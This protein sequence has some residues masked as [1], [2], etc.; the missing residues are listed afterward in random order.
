M[1]GDYGGF[2]TSMPYDI[3]LMANT[4]VYNVVKAFGYN[5]EA[6][7]IV[8]GILS[9]N[10]NPLIVLG[11]TVFRAPAFQP[12]GKYATA[13]DNSLRGLVMLVYAWFK[14]NCDSF[15]EFFDFVLPRIY[16]DDVLAAV[17]PQVTAYFNNI[18]YERICR[19]VYG[20]EYTNAQKT[21][22]MSPFVTLDTCSFLK[23][24]F[25]YCEETGHWVARLDRKSIMKAICFYLPSKND[26]EADQIISSCVSALRELFFWTPR[27]HYDE[28][29][30]KFAAYCSEYYARDQAEILKLFPRFDD[31][32]AQLYGD[33]NFT[34]PQTI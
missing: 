2:D 21:K 1:E 17:K 5:S 32:E 19:V 22:D 14:L 23:R 11:K 12:S 18:E 34:V 30:V 7:K 9:E 3:G 16:G 25:H 28:L 4:I 13:E 29:R 10:L 27:A 24:E 6:L 20:L 8:Q 26:T 31:I 33:G 15:G